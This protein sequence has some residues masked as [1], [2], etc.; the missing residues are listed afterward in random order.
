MTGP[1]VMD[2]FLAAFTRWG[3]PATVLTDNGAIFTATPRRGGRT[4]LQVTLGE[5]GINYINSR[6]Y[7]PQTCGKVCEDLYPTLYRLGLTPAKV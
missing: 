1:D 5:L 4:A 2:T 7:H 3:T 6:P